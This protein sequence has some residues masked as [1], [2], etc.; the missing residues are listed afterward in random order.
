MAHNP[1]APPTA[2]SEPPP[3]GLVFSTEGVEVV[4]N[5]AKW[6]RALSTIYYIFL[7]L[8]VLAGGCSAL[9]AASLMGA[10]AF[11]MDGVTD[12]AIRKITDAA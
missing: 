1:Y 9:A 10:A 7:A 12:L 2:S 8:L 5:M 11:A 6:M 3:A 4:A